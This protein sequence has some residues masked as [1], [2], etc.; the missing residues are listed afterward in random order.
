MTQLTDRSAPLSS[1]SAVERGRAAALTVSFLRGAIA[2]CLGLAMFAV[3]VLA[4]WI[5]SPYPDS[6]AG[7]ALR[8]AGALWLLA[9][10][11]ELVRADTLSGNPAPLGV[12]PLLLMALP[13]WLVYRTARDALEPDEG[14][15]RLSAS[16]VVFTL[17]GGYLLVGAAS[18]L[19]VT[20]APLGA[21]PLR[22][23][24]MLPL[25]TV[26]S[27]V[28]GAWRASGR[29]RGRL[30][31]RLPG[32]LRRALAR[33]VGARAARRR[34]AV[35]LR[36]GVASV[37]LLLGGG[38]LLVGISLAWHGEIAHISFVRLAS[39]WSGRFAVLLLGLVLVPN[40]AMWGAAYGLGPG[41]A[42]GTGATATP[43]GIT[44]DYSLP[45][46]PLLAAVPEGSGSALNWAAAGVPVLAGGALAWF[47]VRVAA[48]P[49]GE[50]EKAWSA[51]ATALTAAFGAVVCAALTALLAAMSGGPMGNGRLAV[52]GPVWWLT[53]AAAL[54]WTLGL[55]V[56]MALVLR[57]WRLRARRDDAVPPSPEP[58]PEPA[59]GA[60]AATRAGETDTK[61][62]AEAVESGGPVTAWW[63]APWRRLMWLLGG[64][65]VA[66]GPVSQPAPEAVGGLGTPVRDADA[67]ADV[68][69]RSGVNARARPRPDARP[70]SGAHVRARARPRSDVR[71][72]SGARA[73]AVPVADR[74]ET[75]EPEFEPYDFLLDETWH[76]RGARQT[77]WAAIKAASS[78]PTADFPAT[79][80][81]S[82]PPS[83]KKSG[84]RKI[85]PDGSAP[86]SGAAPGIGSGV[87]P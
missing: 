74:E 31:A 26:L 30:P 69:G 16:A 71:A 64:R 17:T 68:H 35:A 2:A 5:I 63:P 38:A 65:A 56:P 85:G 52:L 7:G 10:G 58:E 61:G 23:A 76:G 50:K 55:G 8:V 4:M 70:R 51:G 34:A 3:L 72:R 42:L 77:R 83:V 13:V 24:L 20:G 54:V 81:A 79:G 25:V 11:V 14:P 36:A 57:A 86:D 6:G 43:F 47:T 44:G 1:A 62:G 46:F 37:L 33:A 84:P 45:S 18:V 66:D 22:A 82:G 53:G 21:H 87:T 80:T 29:P 15:P 75:K 19:H 9:H 32:V 39:D 78:G 28:A 60:G 27:A 41:F 49:Y 48:P 59:A 40:A 67:R 73:R 12:I